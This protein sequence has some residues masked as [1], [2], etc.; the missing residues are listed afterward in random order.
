MKTQVIIAAAG[1][2]TRLKAKSPKPLICFHRK[3]LLTYSLE[4]FEKCSLVDSVIVVAPKDCLNRFEKTI[5]DFQSKKKIYCVKGGKRRCDSVANGLKALDH[6]TQY[7]VVHDGARPFVTA[8]MLKRCIL[9]AQKYQAAI[10]AVP[11]KPTVKRVDAR[12]LRVKETLKRDELWEVQTPQAFERKVLVKAYARLNVQTPT[13]DAK[14]VE[15][16]GIRPKVV[17]GSYQ[18]IKITTSEDLAFAKFLLTK[19]K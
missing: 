17:F 7:V 1:A 4:V 5:K 19:G 14:L 13:D 9:A 8:E 16:L 2:G 10:V 18:N 12:L 15:A 3:P 6:D 11:I